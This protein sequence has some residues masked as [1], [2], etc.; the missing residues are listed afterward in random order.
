MRRDVMRN[1]RVSR[2]EQLFPCLPCVRTA[3]DL[4]L[5]N[6]PAKSSARSAQDVAEYLL[7]RGLGDIFF[8]AI[9]LDWRGT[10]RAKALT[11][12]DF[13]LR[14]TFPRFLST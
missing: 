4:L 10:I 9:T 13:Y 14:S 8:S 1:T 2:I 6:F 3:V 11:D 5:S 12:I 7:L